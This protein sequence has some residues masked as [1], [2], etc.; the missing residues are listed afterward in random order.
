ML[1][2]IKKMVLV[3]LSV[4]LLLGFG[5]AQA[6]D[7]DE[8]LL[9]VQ[10]NLV[11]V[12]GYTEEEAAGFEIVG[13]RVLSVNEKMKMLEEAYGSSF[14]SMIQQY[15]YGG[16]ENASSD[17]RLPELDKEE[18]QYL[19]N[20][21][22]WA[23]SFA[24]PDHP[25]WVYTMNEVEEDIL[26]SP[27]GE[28]SSLRWSDP[29][30]EGMLRIVLREARENGWF[31][32]W[33]EK[34]RQA[35]MNSVEEHFDYIQGIR[36]PMLWEGISA[37]NAIHELFA[38]VSEIPMELEEKLREWRDAELA[39]YG[40]KLDK[41]SLFAPGSV[42]YEILSMIDGWGEFSE[43]IRATRFVG[44]VPQEIQPYVGH[45]KLEGWTSLCGAV[46]ECRREAPEVYGL[47]AYEKD[48]RRLLVKVEYSR[49]EQ[50]SSVVP[51][52]D[53]ALYTD[54]PMYIV[55]YVSRLWNGWSWHD[56]VY[57]A[58]GY[59][60]SPTEYERFYLNSREWIVLYKRF[61]EATGRGVAI[62]PTLTHENEA[63]VCMYEDY[64]MILREELIQN[65]SSN[66]RMV[67][68]KQF[69]DPDQW[70]CS[71]E[72]VPE[73]YAL[74]RM[75]GYTDGTLVKILSA[76][77]DENGKYTV[78]LGNEQFE[79]AEGCLAVDYSE[80]CEYAD[81][82]QLYN[83]PLDYVKVL[84]P[85][86]LRAGKSE[87]SATLMEIPEGTVLFALKAYPFMNCIQVAAAPNGAEVGWRMQPSDVVGYI[88]AASLYDVST[89]SFI[90]IDVDWGETPLELEWK[91]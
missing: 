73:G 46:F 45:A 63:T 74:L 2:N 86:Q 18:L 78:Q 70:R 64:Q 13:Q 40:L 91:E 38:S 14:R 26:R 4:V 43:P 80:P 41:T 32:K 23:F 6:E 39:S 83:E 52:S 35:L 89:D 72:R 61:D 48:G 27:F 9:Y 67:D 54:R 71:Y 66:I 77:E 8:L 12:F 68:L 17:L 55:P 16:L 1:R 24:H 30:D 22:H 44:A 82:W 57:W 20:T 65:L 10:E 75:T 15:V 53:T 33:T 58:I 69:T 34:A 62:A 84:Y 79:M 42:S 88:S 25:E 31:V 29:V 81:G 19:L 87:S 21:E 50:T 37:G 47:I 56:S 36:P 90:Y 49:E 7:V 28:Y 60:N 5:W 51:L 85:T 11:D 3:I 59:Q 76:P